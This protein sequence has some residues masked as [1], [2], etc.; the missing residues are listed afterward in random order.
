MALIPD[1]PRFFATPAAFRRWLEAHHTK[2][3]ALWVGFHKRGSGT[4]SLTWPES[5]DEALCFGWIDG[6]RVSLDARRYAIRFSPRR[7]GS[8]WSRVNVRKVAA[9]RKAG[10]MRPA[11]LAAFARRRPNRSGIYSFEQRPRAMPA[12]YAKRMKAK[13]GAWE[14]F[15]ARPPSYRRA[16]I[17]WVIGAKQ[18]ATRERRLAIL[19]RDS[20]AGRLIG[21]L[22]PRPGKT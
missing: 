18:E 14:F 16:A 12:K 22:R 11:G 2:A 5:V 20:A 7:P 3:A 1:D 17:W 10:L 6:V 13:P 9:L 8:I 21:L 4:P 19:I 15:R